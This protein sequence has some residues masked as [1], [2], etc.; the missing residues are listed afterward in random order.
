MCVSKGHST[1]LP[2]TMQHTEEKGQG[3]EEQGEERGQGEE[4]QGEEKGQGEEE[5]GEE[6]G[7]EVT[8]KVRQC[9]CVHN[10]RKCV[11]WA[12]C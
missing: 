4:E 8:P 10:N 12:S 9:S 2:L 3:E 7:G 1:S 11:L 5:Q 6:L